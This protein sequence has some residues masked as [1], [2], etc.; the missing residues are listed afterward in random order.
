MDVRVKW[1]FYQTVKENAHWLTGYSAY[2]TAGGDRHDYT[3]GKL[4]VHSKGELHVTSKDTMMLVT[5][6]DYQLTAT[7]MIEENAQGHITLESMDAVT[8]RVGANFVKVDMSGVTIQ[9]M[10]VNIN[11]GGSSNPVSKYTAKIPHRASEADDGTPGYLD[12]PWRGGGGGGEEW[13]TMDGGTFHAPEPPP[14]KEPKLID[15][16]GAGKG[17]TTPGGLPVTKVEH[18]F[19]PDDTK[20]GKNITIKGSEEFQKKTMERLEKMSETE[21][22]RELLKRLEASGK[23]MT[24]TEYTGDNSFSGPEDFQKATPKGLPVYDGAGKPINSWGGLGPQQV[25]TGEGT[26]VKLEFNPNL[27]LPNP[28]NGPMPNDGVLFHEMNHGLHQM[29]GDADCVPV[30]GFDTK[31]EEKTIS[32]GD[33]NEGEYLKQSGYPYKRTDHD[34][35]WTDNK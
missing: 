23:T 34:T 5:S 35:T 14:E 11:S 27:N 33:L 31:E 16:S 9:G 32:T 12:R 15:A 6:K 2:Q 20:L 18:W 7:G 29:G 10:M 24:I 26:D 21:Q 13:E 1:N 25:G 3:K 30:P 22:G 17:P 19:G 4:Y 28:K 8:L